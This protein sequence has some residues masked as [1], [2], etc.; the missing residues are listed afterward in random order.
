MRIANR[1]NVKF[2]T[3]LIKY[4]FYQYALSFFY[5]AVESE[6]YL[7][8]DCNYFLFSNMTEKFYSNSRVVTRCLELGISNQINILGISLPR[9]IGKGSISVQ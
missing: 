2:N 7:S 5:T 9:V 8:H 6:Q 4:I 1:R 3:A